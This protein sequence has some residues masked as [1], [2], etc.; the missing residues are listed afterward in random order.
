MTRPGV[1]R[2]P[3]GRKVAAILVPWVFLAAFATMYVAF[4]LP[5]LRDGQLVAVCVGAFISMVLV[6]FV[7]AAIT[8]SRDVLLDRWPERP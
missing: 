2:T 8:F 5:R 3:A 4:V 7:V 1:D 6:V